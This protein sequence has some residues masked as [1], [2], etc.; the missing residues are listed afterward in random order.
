MDSKN[1]L[2]AAGLSLALNESESTDVE[3][4]TALN[5]CLDNI[6]SDELVQQPKESKLQE[7]YVGLCAFFLE[8]AKQ[9]LSETEFVLSLHEATGI[10][11]SKRV[12][13]LTAAFNEHLHEIRSRLE[14]LGVKGS[15]VTDSL[16]SLACRLASTEVEK[17]GEANCLV[18]LKTSVPGNDIQFVCS[19]PQ[20]EDLVWTLR[21]ASKVVERHAQ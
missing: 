7:M 5:V 10:V 17:L 18:K 4:E 19:L 1:L 15:A 8:A 2:E 21:Q 9:D 16:A 11:D 12:A 6:I 3:F 14:E 20:L 13:I